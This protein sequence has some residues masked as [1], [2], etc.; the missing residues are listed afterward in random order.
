MSD[1]I[2]AFRLP[3]TDDFQPCRIVA[4]V[5]QL[6]LVLSGGA[7]PSAFWRQAPLLSR[8]GTASLEQSLVRQ[9]FESP[10]DAGSAQAKL[11]AHFCLRERFPRLPTEIGR[12]PKID[13]QRRAAVG[14]VLTDFDH[15][16]RK[17]L[18]ELFPE[19]ATFRRIGSH[20]PL[21]SIWPYKGRIIRLWHLSHPLSI[22][23]VCKLVPVTH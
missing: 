5:P 15:R 20:V 10:P 17:Y 22:C 1:L 23:R 12:C 4:S 18:H 13:F 7:H 9:K 16:F 21:P 3:V 2:C 19:A 6:A 8:P 11:L 14:L